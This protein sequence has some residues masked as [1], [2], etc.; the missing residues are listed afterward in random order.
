MILP[1]HLRQRS[2]SM[3][4]RCRTINIT[5]FIKNATG[6]EN[7]CGTIIQHYY[8]NTFKMITQYEVYA[9]LQHEIPELTVK[10]YPSDV[11]LEIYFSISCFADYTKHALERHSFHTAKKCLAIAENLYV[12]GDSTVRFLI[13]NNFV[14]TF[15]SQRISKRTD[16]HII[17]SIFPKTLYAVYKKQLMGNGN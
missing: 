2:E 6:D 14:F 10:A 15:S 4:K 1:N 5:K 9:L 17:K 12:N 13:E 8:A 3:I 11:S 16:D 7:L